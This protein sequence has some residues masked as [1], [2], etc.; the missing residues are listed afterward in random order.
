VSNHFDSAK[1]QNVGSPE[2][3]RSVKVGLA[4]R[5]ERRPLELALA[6]YLVLVSFRFF[7]TL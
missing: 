7:V 1:A 5:L 6:A 2:K 4:H 3:L